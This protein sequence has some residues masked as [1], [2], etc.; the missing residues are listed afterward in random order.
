MKKQ[1]VL[2]AVL[3]VFL[4]LMVW[5]GYDSYRRGLTSPQLYFGGTALTLCCIAGLWFH[6]GRRK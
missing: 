6:L 5:L 1:I 3:L 2:P 4:L